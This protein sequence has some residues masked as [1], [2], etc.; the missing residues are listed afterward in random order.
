VNK[1][2]SL[3]EVV[4]CLLILQVGIIATFGMVLLSQRSFHRAEVTLRGVLE[5]GWIADS[6]FSSG[7]VED[8]FLHLPWGDVFW[9]KE[10]SPVPGLRFSVWSPAL[11]DTVVK[12]FAV[13]P[14]VG[15]LPDFPDPPG[16]GLPW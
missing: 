12:H 7:T 11:E 3:V 2:F 15:I 1:G 16:G 14:A 8:G 4:L 10:S 9:W 5:A 6:L 13:E